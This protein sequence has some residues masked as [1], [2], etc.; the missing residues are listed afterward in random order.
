MPK[1]KDS[2]IHVQSISLVIARWSVSQS[3]P[4]YIHHKI[5]PPMTSGS[6]ILSIERRF[7]GISKHYTLYEKSFLRNCAAKI[8]INPIRTKENA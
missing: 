1:G 6:T 8:A 4:L 3:K 2:H 7:I 5:A